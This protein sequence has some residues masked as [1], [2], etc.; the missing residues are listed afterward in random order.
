MVSEWI[1]DEVN[2]SK[3]ATGRWEDCDSVGSGGLW[4][5]YQRRRVETKV[6][7]VERGWGRKRVLNGE[8]FRLIEMRSQDEWKRRVEGC[9]A[10]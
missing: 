5:E 6:E 7:S 2:R 8:V 1:E 10:L 3:E 4:D 9:R